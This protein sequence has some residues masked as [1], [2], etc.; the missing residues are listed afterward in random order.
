MCF[1]LDRRVDDILTVFYLLLSTNK[2]FLYFICIKLKIK[3][4]KYKKERRE[5][6]EIVNRIKRVLC[7]T[8]MPK[9]I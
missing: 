1:Q 7:V 4:I 2:T 3:I 5:F 6:F 9:V 8:S